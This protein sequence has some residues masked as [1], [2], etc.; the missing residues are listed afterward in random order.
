MYRIGHIE[1]TWGTMYKW[2]D[3]KSSKLC[4]GLS[5]LWLRVNLAADLNSVGHEGFGLGGIWAQQGR[6]MGSGMGDC[7]R[8]KGT[9]SAITGLLVA[10]IVEVDAEVER[11]AMPF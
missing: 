11:Y 1:A 2:W 7:M 8:W 10:W 3:F 9:L 4:C 6:G 5:V